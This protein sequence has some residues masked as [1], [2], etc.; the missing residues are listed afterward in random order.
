MNI[1]TILDVIGYGLTL[2]GQ[3]LKNKDV[4]DSAQI[5][6]AIEDVYDAIDGAVTRRITP[7]AALRELDRLKADIAANDAAADTALDVKFPKGD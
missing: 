5:V 6:D 4:E 1:K 7:E 2:I 3:L